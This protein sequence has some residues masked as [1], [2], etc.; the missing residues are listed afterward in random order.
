MTKLLERMFGSRSLTAPASSIVDD[1]RQAT[2]ATLREISVVSANF[3]APDRGDNALLASERRCAEVTQDL[4]Q[5]ATTLPSAS[6]PFRVVLMGRTQ[7]GKS[8]LFNYLTGGEQSLV[9]S[10]GQGTTK[11]VVPAPLASCPDVL[12]VDTPGVGALDR[13]EDRVTALDEART[14]DLVVWVAA[15][16]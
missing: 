7:A 2:A 9:G 4:L 10:G 8:T 6:G 13:P 16:M 14:A 3:T 15:N 5:T 12:V 1:A 11:H